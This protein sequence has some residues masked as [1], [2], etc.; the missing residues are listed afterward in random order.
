M[1]RT[2]MR[3]AK[4]S[5]RR[6]SRPRTRRTTLT[7]PED[8]LRRV[9]RLAVKRHQSVSAAIATLVEAPLRQLEVQDRHGNG[10]DLLRKSMEGLTEEEQMLIDGIILEKP[11]AESE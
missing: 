10:W 3:T 9:E 8:L 5:R 4:L 2:K 11:G 1:L 7:L 6:S